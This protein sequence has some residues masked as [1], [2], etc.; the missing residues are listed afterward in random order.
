MRKTLLILGAGFLGAE[1][2]RLVLAEGA[3]V[4]GTTR[5]EERARGLRALGVE[6]F[7]APRLEASF[8][9]SLDLPGM[10]V[11]LTFP[12][13]P[14]TDEAIAPELG[15]A[16][17]IVYISSTGVY[18][19]ASGRIDEE[20]PVDPREPRARARLQ[21]EER[22]RQAGA[23]VLRAAA[24][25]GPH[26]GLHTRLRRGEH[27]IAEGGR[28]VVSRIH[29]EDLARLALAALDRGP[30]G[31][32]FVVADDAPVPQAEV[33]AWLVSE[34]GFSPPAEVSKSALPETLRH[35]RSSDGRKIQRALGVSLV[36]PTYR[37][38]FLAC[39]RA[40]GNAG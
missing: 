40:E 33:I 17:S 18:G 31:E 22:Y 1:A 15:R 14:V 26:R 35:D 9:R 32:T 13:D 19:D 5:S 10:R 20:T 39:L 23:I 29:V 3:R 38:G 16:A 36:Y 25:Y 7:V 2:A 27:K 34:M 24:I 4:L 37:E 21:A 12:P 28:S 8:L 6:V 30:R 11:L